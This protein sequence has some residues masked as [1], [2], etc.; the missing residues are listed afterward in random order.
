MTAPEISQMF[1]ELDRRLVRSGLAGMGAPCPVQ[2]RR[3][4]PG[5]RHADGRSLARRTRSCPGFAS[6]ARVHLVETSPVLRGCRPKRS[7]LTRPGMMI[8]DTRARGAGHHHRQRVLRC[9]PDPAVRMAR[10]HWIGA[11]VG[12]EADGRLVIRPRLAPAAPKRAGERGSHHRDWHQ[13]DAIAAALGARLAASPGAALIIDYGHL[14]RAGRHAAGRPAPRY[15]GIL[16]RP[17]EADLTAHVDFEALAQALRRGGAV[18]HGPMTQRHFLLA[19][20]LEARA[21]HFSARKPCRA[22][23]RII[24]SARRAPCRRG[25]NG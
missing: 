22:E 17:G 10:G 20:G 3:A 18:V 5:A 11:C 24:A 2:S 8:F 16:D 15:C 4:R 7:V 13:R 21:L 23:R 1:G 14:Q 6:A 12:L 9:D 25:T 19:M